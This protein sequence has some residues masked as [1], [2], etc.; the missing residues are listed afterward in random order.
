MKAQLFTID[1]ANVKVF[2]KLVK[3][4][5]QEVKNYSPNRKVV[6]LEMHQGQEVKNYGPNKKVLP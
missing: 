5:C 2:K 6:S 3:L 4:Q 1:M